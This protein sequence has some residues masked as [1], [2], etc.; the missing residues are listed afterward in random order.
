ME[1]NF[2]FPILENPA[3]WLLA[4]IM[5][6]FMFWFAGLGFLLDFQGAVGMM[7]AEGMPSPA[8][9]AGLTIAVQLIGSGL[10]I[11]GRHAW[12]GAAILAGFTLM[13]IPLVHDFWNMT[14]AAAVQAR[15]ESEE[16]LSMIGGLIG[17]SIMSHLAG[18]RRRGARPLPAGGDR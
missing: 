9:V 11:Q 3:L 6:T 18:A 10:V 1:R 8:L 2:V 4:R 12:F 13:T 7:Q 17:I 5:V 14:G 15:L 16:H